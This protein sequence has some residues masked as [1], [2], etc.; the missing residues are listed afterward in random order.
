MP[1]GHRVNADRERSALLNEIYEA[2][3]LLEV[4]GRVRMY[5]DS[6][7]SD[8]NFSI[9]ALRRTVDSLAG[10]PGRKAILYLSD[11]LGMR[12]AE[13]MFYAL[14]DRF[15]DPL[16]SLQIQEFDV[17]RRFRE[18]T[19]E[20][21][22]SRVTFYTLDAAGL[23]IPAAADAAN[24]QV[25]RGTIVDSAYVANLQEPLRYMASETGGQAIVNTNNFGPLLD[26]VGE[27]FSTY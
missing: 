20:A 21:S 15:N 3:E 27:D 17:S 24:Y 2:D 5:A 7:Y 10:R 22:S 1:S 19:R 13:D 4:S 6:V 23:R 16:A 14:E 12:A 26:R 9:D 25:R 18:L 11:G 8:L